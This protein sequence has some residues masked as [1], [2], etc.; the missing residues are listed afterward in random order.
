[1]DTRTA[2]ERLD[3]SNC[4]PYPFW[5]IY[6]ERFFLGRIAQRGEQWE[7]YFST[8]ELGLFPTLDE[9]RAAVVL[10]FSGLDIEP[11]K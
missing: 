10:W 11:G 5:H 4:E 7:V 8:I 6:Y 1:M 3:I 9:A 2:V